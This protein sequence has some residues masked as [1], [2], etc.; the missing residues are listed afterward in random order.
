MRSAFHDTCAN[1]R[2]AR[3]A[4][5]GLYWFINVFPNTWSQLV[6]SPYVIGLLPVVVSLVQ[7]WSSFCWDDSLGPA[8]LPAGRRAYFWRNCVRHRYSYSFRGQWDFA[9]LCFR[10]FKLFDLF[11]ITV[12]VLI[13]YIRWYDKTKKAKVKNFI[14]LSFCI[15]L[16]IFSLHRLLYIVYVIW[17]TFSWSNIQLIKGF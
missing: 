4:L 13:Y 17:K 5:V 16:L 1:T 10:V 3:S 7:I 14:S 6:I 9:F 8:V 2:K 12:S 15:R 11:L